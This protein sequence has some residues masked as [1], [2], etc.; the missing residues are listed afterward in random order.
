MRLKLLTLT[1]P[2]FSLVFLF[3]C[4]NSVNTVENQNKVMNPTIVPHEKIIT[5]SS[6]DKRLA[7]E[8]VVSEADGACA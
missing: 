5:D 8:R 7:V 1:I 4:R 2:A 6:T 3:S